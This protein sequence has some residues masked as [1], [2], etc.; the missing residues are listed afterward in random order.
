MYPDHYLQESDV[1]DVQHMPE[2]DQ[3]TSPRR[4]PRHYR[5]CVLLVLTLFGL[6]LLATGSGAGSGD[7]HTVQR[8]TS[9]LTGLV[10]GGDLSFEV[11]LGAGATS[12]G[13]ANAN[14]PAAVCLNPL[15]ATC[16]LQNA[17]QWMAQ[18][19]MG[20]L[21][22][23]IGAIMHNPLNILTQTPPADTYQNPVVI[24]WWQSF[25]AVV[26]LALASLI[27]IGGYNVVVGR[28]LGL[29]HSELAE[30]LPRLLLAFGA[31]HFSLFFLGLFIDLENALDLVALNLAGTSM[32]TNIITALFQGNLATEGL[33]V[34]VLTFVLGVMAILLG[35]QMAVR[36]ALLWVLLVLSGLGLACFALPQTIGYGRTWLSLTATTVMVQFFQVVTL[37]LGGML[38]TSLGASN[39]FG[40]G[41][42]LATLLVC[43]AL[44]YLVLRIPGIVHRFALRPMMDASRAATGA[45]TG[46]VGVVAD[47]A[48]RLLAL[49]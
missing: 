27:V 39:V 46:A 26:D 23:V 33:L 24:T 13:M 3:R 34:W 18:Q 30:F 40:V 7:S 41:G 38:L 48:P 2:R 25:L 6:H 14:A 10:V 28:H 20:A 12:G 9:G 45:A 44:L 47:V 5:Y 42:T 11:G 35:A 8:P 36:L 16:W 21:Q 31:A 49:L 22:P 1:A 32:L 19:V 37:A 17:A 29:P 43:V 4:F 15:D